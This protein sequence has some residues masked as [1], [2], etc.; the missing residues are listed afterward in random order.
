MPFPENSDLAAKYNVALP[1]YTSYPTMP[2]WDVTAFNGD[3]WK[4]SAKRSYEE[5][6][7]TEGIS[8]Y[9]HLPFCENL[10]TYCGCNT[11]ITKN[12]AVEQPY[13]NGLILEWTMYLNMFGTKPLIKEIHLGGGTPTFFSAGHLKI[14]LDA[15]LLN[16]E[17]HPD[18]HFSFEAHPAN[19]S[20]AHLYTLYDLGF[21]RLSLGIQDFDPDVQRIINR[22]QSFEQVQEITLTARAIGYTSINFDLIYGLPLQTTAGLTKTIKLVSQ[23]KPDRIAFY[24]YAHVPWL[25]P[26]QRSFTEQH[27][28]DAA[29]K[30]A[31]HQTGRDLLNS[32]GYME[33]G[34]D[35]F[36]L[37]GDELL[38]AMNKGVLY[39]NFMGYTDQHT[40]LLIGLGVSA[41][42]DSGYAF[43]Q[44][45]KNVEEYLLL[46][47]DGELPVFKGHLLTNEDLVIRKHIN[48]I[49]CQGKTSWNHHL[50][51]C[52]SLFSGLERLQ[53]LADDG[54][55]ELC[56]FGLKVTP[57]GKGF[58]RNICMALDARL[59]AD[60]PGTQ[61]FSMAM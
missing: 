54:I 44:N 16:T 41:I 52:L 49:M 1:R 4:L 2:Y 8:L 51:P 17:I 13:I 59:W 23:L 38:T 24:S 20:K 61:L 35:H 18:A 33:V 31:L 9:I 3:D 12:H 46:V 22:E 56:S 10:R 14:L 6:N 57:L 50:E 11:R 48:N 43:A 55:I 30:K 25:K 40:Q 53:P 47:A 5:S 37:T 15:I 27:L 34:M 21:R 42:S 36:A 19:T 29:A 60:K 28:P 45:V 7:S 58:L 39:R 26:G 32:F